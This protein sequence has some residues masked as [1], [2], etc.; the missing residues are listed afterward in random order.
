VIISTVAF[1]SN[2][3]DIQLISLPGPF[4]CVIKAFNRSKYH[5][6][7]WVIMDITSITCLPS[8]QE[9]IEGN[10]YPYHSCTLASLRVLCVEKMDCE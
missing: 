6:H 7:K 8:D 4:L 2:R 1:Q 3:M 5:V 10:A 9:T